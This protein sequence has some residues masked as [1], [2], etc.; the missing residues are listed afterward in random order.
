MTKLPHPVCILTDDSVC[1]ETLLKYVEKE[2]I[3]HVYELSKYNQSLTSRML[4]IS[5]GTLRSKLKEYFGD[6]YL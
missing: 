5:R 1:T 4:K 6:K 3:H 2:C